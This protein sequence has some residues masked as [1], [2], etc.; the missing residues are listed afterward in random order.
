MTGSVSEFILSIAMGL[1][2]VP[3][4]SDVHISSV[5]VPQ[6]SKEHISHY[7]K[8]RSKENKAKTA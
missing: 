7:D 3:D 1:H 4:Y 6:W 5:I 2:I 8:F